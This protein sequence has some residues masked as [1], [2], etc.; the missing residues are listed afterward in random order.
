M[1]KCVTFHTLKTSF[2]VVMGAYINH[3]LHFFGKEM[4]AFHDPQAKILYI[5]LKA[6]LVMLHSIIGLM[7]VEVLR[8]TQHSALLCAILAS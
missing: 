7:V 5:T 2:I 3:N 6:L 4:I 8:L 1:H